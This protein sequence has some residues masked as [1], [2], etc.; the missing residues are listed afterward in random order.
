MRSIRKGITRALLV[1]SVAAGL[2]AGA[3]LARAAAMTAEQA[4]AAVEIALSERARGNT[5]GVIPAIDPVIVAFEGMQAN[6]RTFCAQNQPQTLLLLLGA[7][8]E[9]DKGKAP[10][11][12]TKTVVVDH[13]YCTALFLKG[14]MLIDLGRPGE[15][16]AFLR[17][18]HEAE[19]YNAHFLNEYAEWYK[20]AGQ[21]QRAHD[22]FAEAVEK[23]ELANDPEKAPYKARA[24]RGMGFTEIELGKL[25]DAESH[26][27]E[28]QKYDPDNPAVRQEIEYIARL[29]RRRTS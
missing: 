14:F 26:M 5:S 24:L 28:S 10:V 23:S 16:E 18:A 13:A 1:A 21:W 8:A 20:M 17:R 12:A 7:A 9:A 6:E 22:L 27:R 3:P 2:A 25:D 4:R 29:R 15:A 19:P 11:P